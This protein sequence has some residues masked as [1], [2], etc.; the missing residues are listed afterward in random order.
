MIM[1]SMI[2]KM[3]PKVFLLDED[4]LISNDVIVFYWGKNSDLIEGVLD[5]FLWEIGEFYF[6]QSIYLVV[7]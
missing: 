4:F 1:L 5:L 3:V 6:F 2:I 7:F